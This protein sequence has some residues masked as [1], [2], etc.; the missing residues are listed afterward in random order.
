M[1]DNVTVVREDLRNTG[2]D[3][4]ETTARE[5]QIYRFSTFCSKGR[6]TF[7]KVTL[8]ALKVNVKKF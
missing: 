4:Y 5:I 6:M 2:G 7:R 8:A 3:K 1:T